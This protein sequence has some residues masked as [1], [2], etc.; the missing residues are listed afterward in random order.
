MKKP[1]YVPHLAVYNWAGQFCYGKRVL[2]LGSGDGYGM[3]VLSVYAKSLIGIDDSQVAFER[4]SR[5]SPLCPRILVHGDVTQASAFLDRVDV[6]TAFEIIEHIDNPI[7]FCKTLPGNGRKII[8]SVPH[9][10]PHA[11][12]KT[13]YYSEAD[14]AALFPGLVIEWYYLTGTN[15]VKEKPAKFERYV[16]IV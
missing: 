8:F 14:V 4:A 6:I 16:C 11:L 5:M 9:A 12:H 15:I 3:L 10:Y 2:D 7:E 13:N 1:T